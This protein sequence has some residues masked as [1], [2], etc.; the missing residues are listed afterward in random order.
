MRRHSRNCQSRARKISLMSEELSSKFFWHEGTLCADCSVMAKKRIE[1]YFKF[2][3]H[4]LSYVCMCARARMSSDVDQF[5]QRREKE[6]AIIYLQPINQ[7]SAFPATRVTISK[8]IWINCYSIRFSTSCINLLVVI[9]YV[10]LYF[11]YSR[12]QH[13]SIKLGISFPL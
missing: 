5:S 4:I 8:C 1:R 7:T 2:F 6:E 12:K 13:N 11:S 9:R 3:I 10:D